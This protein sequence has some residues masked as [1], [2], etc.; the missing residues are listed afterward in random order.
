[1]SNLFTIIFLLLALSVTGQEIK[2]KKNQILIDKE[3][4]YN[5]TKTQ[6]NPVGPQG[7]MF[8]LN[9]HFFLESLDGEKIISFTDTSFYYVQLPNETEKRVAFRAMLFTAHQLGKIE[10]YN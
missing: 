1:M 2:F 10:R 3:P 9:G 7:A 4:A 5:F 8:N 6:G